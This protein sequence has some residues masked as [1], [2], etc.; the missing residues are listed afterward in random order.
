MFQQQ[1]VPKKK[2]K[3]KPDDNTSDCQCIPPELEEIEEEVEC[4]VL[5]P[6][7][8]WKK[9]VKPAMCWWITTTKCERIFSDKFYGNPPLR[10]G[11]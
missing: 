9:V 8:Q 7:Y 4:E 6:G 5:K 10:K 3:K 1:K 2:E 11:M